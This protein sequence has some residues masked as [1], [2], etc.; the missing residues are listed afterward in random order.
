MTGEEILLVLF[1]IWLFAPRGRRSRS[2]ARC[3]QVK[4]KGPPGPRPVTPEPVYICE[5]CGMLIYT[6]HG[7]TREE[8][9]NYNKE[10]PFQPDHRCKSSIQEGQAG[11]N[12]PKIR[13][14]Y[15]YKAGTFSN[16]GVGKEA[17]L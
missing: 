7:H 17:T 11:R 2:R 3:R 5:N 6:G 1:L 14:P 8:C 4:L 10:R 12:D 9:E 13:L 15:Y 16:W